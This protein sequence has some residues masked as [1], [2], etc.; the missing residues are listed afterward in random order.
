MNSKLCKAL[1]FISIILI[2]VFTGLPQG[3]KGVK[4][5]SP[6]TQVKLRAEQQKKL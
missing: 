5:S 2:P 3:K 6:A 1:F 4:I